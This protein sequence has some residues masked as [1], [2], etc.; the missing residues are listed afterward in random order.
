MSGKHL[1]II[2][3]QFLPKQTLKPVII[4]AAYSGAKVDFLYVYIYI[5]HQDL[6]ER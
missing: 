2:R 1:P 3:E 4:P 5:Y 6:K